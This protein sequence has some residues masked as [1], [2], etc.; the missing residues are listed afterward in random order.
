MVLLYYLRFGASHS[1]PDLP[2]ICSPIHSRAF[3]RMAFE[4]SPCAEV[5]HR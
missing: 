4:S 3:V 1:L 2:C 5:L